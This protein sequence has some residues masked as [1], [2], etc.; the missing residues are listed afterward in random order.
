MIIATLAR[1]IIFTNK[2]IR[3]S[4]SEQQSRSK[5]NAPA[6]WGATEGSVSSAAACY[7]ALPFWET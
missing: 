7:V 3:V 6:H 4:I 5:Y 1:L 2:T